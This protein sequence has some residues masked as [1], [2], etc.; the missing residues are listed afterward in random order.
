VSIALVLA[1]ALSAQAAE[2]QASRPQPSRPL[3]P[4]PSPVIEG[5]V[6][7][8]D[9]KPVEHALV[10]AERSQGGRGEPALSARTDAQGA[11]QLVLKRSSPYDVHVEAKGLAAWKGAKVRP[12]TSLAVVLE[13]GLA[14]EGVV[15]DGSSRAPVPGARVSTWV[16][17]GLPWEPGSGVVTAST[18]AKG[19]YRLE[20]LPRGLLEIQAR[21][22]GYG[23]ARRRNVRAGGTADL[24]LFPGSSLSGFVL[25]PDGRPVADA[26]VRAEADYA[27]GAR[28]AERTDAKGR[29]ELIGIPSGSYALVAVHPDF[30]PGVTAGVAIDHG[31]DA[32]SDVSLARGIPV[33][34][35][36]LGTDDAPVAGNLVVQ[37]LNGHPVSRALAELLRAEAG[38]DGRFRLEKLPPGSHALSVLAPGHAPTRVDFDVGSRAAAVDVG[39]V[40]LEAGLSI[41]GRVSDR[42]GNLVA[43]ATILGYA[44]QPRN[45]AGTAEA[46][47]G[48]DGR[49]ALSGLSH[50]VYRLRVE[51]GGYGTA[52]RSAAAGEENLDLVLEPA[53]AITGVA[54]DD[55][56]QPIDSYQVAAHPTGDHQVPRTTDVGTADGRFRLEDVAGGTYLLQLTAPERAP[57]TRSD[58]VVPAGGSVDVGRIRLARGGVVRGTVADLQGS[59]VAGATVSVRPAGGD[60]SDGNEPEEGSDASGAFEVRG[61]AAG[62]SIVVARHP[63]YAE[64]Q[65]APVEVDPARGAA[66]AHIVLMQ[67]GRIE[68]WARRRD[69]GPIESALVHLMPIDAAS[70]RPPANHAVRP[71]GSF[72]IEHVA[73]G[74]VRVQLTQRQLGQ[75]AGGWTRNVEVREGETSVVE[76]VQRDILVSGHVRR[77]GEPAPGWR[78]TL[79]G[80]ESFVAIHYGAPGQPSA[81]SGGPQRMTAVTRDDGSYELLADEPGQATVLVESADGRVSLP[82]RMVEIPDADSFALDL[83]FSSTKVSGLVADKETGQ[84]IAEARVYAQKAERDGGPA[85]ARSGLDGR[86]QLELDPGQYS[87]FGSAEGYARGG[88]P[89]QVPATSEVVLEL[90]RGAVLKGRV[91]DAA[92]RGVA[93][94]DVTAFSGEA[95]VWS[96]EAWA[97]THP[98]GSFQF[99]ALPRRPHN[100]FADAGA[101]G[102]A[103]ARGAVPG[104]APVNLTLRP[105]GRVQLLVRGPDGLPLAGAYPNL[106]QVDGLGVMNATNLPGTDAQGLVELSL[107][108]GRV[109][110]KVW[111][112]K[113]RG[114]VSVEVPEGGSVTAEVTLAPSE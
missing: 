75:A 70:F 109:Q 32:R 19:R 3:R 71:D 13:K 103:L 95:D 94:L 84:P 98:D 42:A 2:S 85:R 74:R 81:P 51:A 53:G 56:G 57:A 28:E 45:P 80:R 99:D 86:F 92:G 30:A 10:V 44:S 90:S 114:S 29:F 107:P 55:A 65:S 68:G 18:D 31:A 7:A 73:P 63:D 88:M 87:L 37:E 113:V 82:A 40:R 1:A 112:D 77:G 50:A 39:D 104:G 14:V 16:G 48:P 76:F 101:V 108:T 5:T 69:G 54:V 66:E 83:D 89:I 41:R 59:P 26:V 60:Y 22:P 20:G 47:S 8:P 49:F 15:R 43:D 4:T 58:I 110:L 79:R 27:R 93:G 33:T 97:Y 100:V 21:A 62:A 78:L 67:G 38:A 61:V 52:L 91:V 6:K 72:T 96:G 111:K 23:R 35:R 46:R 9:G 36:L 102:F 25:D 106:V 11:F 64:G 12:G 105:P 24:N 34:G 17:D